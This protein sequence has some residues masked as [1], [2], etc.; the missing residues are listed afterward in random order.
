MIGVDSTVLF[1]G[2]LYKKTPIFLI[3]DYCWYLNYR[4]FIE[5]KIGSVINSSDDFIDILKTNHNNNIKLSDYINEFNNTLF[6]KFI[7][8]VVSGEN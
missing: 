6:L 2:L 3:D 7:S 4:L 5:N 1:E 8:G